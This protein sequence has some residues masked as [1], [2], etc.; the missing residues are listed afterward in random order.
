MKRKQ[1]R[2]A[3]RC[4]MPNMVE[5]RIVVTGNFRAWRDVLAVRGTVHADREIRALACE[6]GRQL[7]LLA[8][9]AFQD[10]MVY[11]DTDGHES[12][13]FEEIQ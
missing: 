9:H 8:P 2:E 5:T 7:K 3:A 12:L 4:V 10:L 1:A 11:T 13:R 6:L